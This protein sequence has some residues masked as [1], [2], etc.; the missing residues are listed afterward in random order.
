MSNWRRALCITTA[1]LTL[2]AGSL[3]SQAADTQP[4]TA[5]QIDAAIERAVDSLFALQKD[6]G[7]WGYYGDPASKDKASSGYFEHGL[8]V[9]AMMGLAYGEADL[10]DEKMKKGLKALLEAKIDKNYVYAVRTIALAKLYP[11]LD[12]E[13]KE[14][15][16]KVLQED[17]AW[18]YKAQHEEGDWNYPGTGMGELSNTQ[19]AL[20]GVYEASAIF[21]ELPND[22]W[23]KAMDRYLKIQKPDGGWNY[24]S[25]SSIHVDMP[26]YGSMSAAAVAS[27]MIARDKLYGATGCPCKGGKSQRRG[28]EVLDKAIDDGIKW[29]AANFKTN[30]NPGRGAYL[31]YW[32]FSCERVGLA[33][34]MKYFGTHDWY[35]EFATELLVRQR[36]DGSWGSIPNTALAIAF[37]AKGRAP[38]LFNKMQF[39]GQWNNHPRDVANLAAHLG[40][41]KEQAIQWQTINL[42][43]PVAE[44]HDAP[45]V[46]FSAESPVPFTDEQKKKLREYTDTGGTILFE[47][48]CGNRQAIQ[49][50]EL[51]C[52][53]VWPEWELKLVDRDHPLWTAD[54][55]IRG[56]LPNLF[57]LSDGVRT[58]VF[59]SKVDLSCAWNTMGVTRDPTVFDLGGNLWMYATDK[60]KLRSRLTGRSGGTGDKYAATA[61]AA[62]ERKEIKLAR[63]K[64]G[65]QWYLAQNYR[66]WQALAAELQAKAGVTLSE[67]EP[68]APGA[69]VPADVRALYYSGRA[70]CT[71]PPDGA[72]WLR[73]FIDG[74]GF[75]IAEATLGNEEFDETLK[76]TVKEAGLELRVLPKDHPLFTGQMGGATG[77]AVTTVGYSFHLRPER[78]DKPDPTLIG[79][80]DKE[81]LVGVYSPLDLMVSQT[82]YKAYGIRGYEPE[83]ARALA[84]NLALYLTRPAP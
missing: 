78:I 48:S 76:A 62:G 35:R 5:E 63:I 43:V 44:W 1:G 41:Q 79:I 33:S 74:G 80:M 67:V 70:G 34:G 9:C 50:W 7:T 18:T 69:E 14:L 71:L 23:Q 42:D 40:R 22:I 72:A 37:L 32:F 58:L 29:M 66:P 3:A 49:A 65:G 57:G 81:K 31:D 59:F 56:R 26:T 45:I 60:G 20:L 39:D 25:R 51:V 52:K 36:P 27:L 53:E 77:Y 10:K 6:D 55:T 38:I 16:K 28:S 61:P 46:Y 8:D 19:M 24:G 2:L 30:E 54:A 83:D 4:I 12:R 15:V 68:L 84:M 82:F 75:L 47:A 11:R 13:L 64:H 73:K 17:V 21:K